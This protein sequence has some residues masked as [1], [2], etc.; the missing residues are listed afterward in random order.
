MR[1][2][3]A[4]LPH[5]LTA[6]LSLSL[7]AL[8]VGVSI[9]LPLGALA[10]RRPWLAQ[11]AQSAAALVQTIPSLALLALMVP[12]LG[13]LG[14]ASIGFLPAFLALVLYSLLPVLGNTITALTTLPAEI[15]EAAQGVGMNRWQQLTRVELPLALPVIV[16]GI[17]T[18]AV[19]TVGAATLATPVGADSLGNFIFSGLQTR[20]FNAVLVGCVASA[21][22][23]LLL[24][25]LGKLLLSGIARRRRSRTAFA[26]AALF[27]LYAYA[28]V[29]LASAR[30]AAADSLVVGAKTFTEQYI[31][32]DLLAQRLRDATERPV[33]VRASLGS[34]VAFDALESG[35]ID[36]YV[37]YSGTLWSNVMKRGAPPE[38]S[39]MLREIQTYLAG[40]GLRLVAELGF[41]NSYAL[42]MQRS[43]AEQLQVRGIGDLARVSAELVMGA[44]YEFFARPE[45]ALLSRTYG[46]DFRERRSMDP[47]LMYQAVATGAV[48]VI[49]AFST[50]GRIAAYDLVVLEDEQRAIP[51]YDALV[52]V[53]RRL[54]ERY[55]RGVDALAE[56]SH[57]LDSEQMRR[58][59]RAVDIDR[60][61]VAE[62]AREFSK[63]LPGP[64]R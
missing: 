40:R 10:A 22:L 51:P 34:T 13:A 4:L 59:N 3:L 37:D 38:R 30:F 55:P 24:D 49:S 43:R 5:L 35:G 26:L 7:S 18:A 11:L 54:V 44:D 60:R 16:A 50:D 33:Q 17:R 23:A 28:G 20:N 27:S 63:L 39:Q 64:A 9:S 52:L 19:W 1:E 12:L 29:A 48:D 53:G 31:L 8:L 61:S 15:S 45:W 21:A 57:V 56:L 6:H 46:I 2:Q 32:A 36:A 42:A 14:G 25:G 41:E 62:V 58:L 47:S